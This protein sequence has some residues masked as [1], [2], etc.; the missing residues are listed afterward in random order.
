MTNATRICDLFLGWGLVNRSTLNL[1]DHPLCL[2]YAF[3]ESQGHSTN[4]STMTLKW[5]QINMNIHSDFTNQ[6]HQILIEYDAV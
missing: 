4:F 3:N 1:P 6:F 5:Y 2:A